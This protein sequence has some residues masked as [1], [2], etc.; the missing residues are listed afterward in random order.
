MLWT[1][2]ERS[3]KTHMFLTLFKMRYYISTVLD[4]NNRYLKVDANSKD[5]IL[6]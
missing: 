3:E 1:K 6:R 2:N 4:I 5:F